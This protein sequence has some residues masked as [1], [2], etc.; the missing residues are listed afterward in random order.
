MSVSKIL[1]NLVKISKKKNNEESGEGYFLEVNVKCLEKLL[2]L[3]NDLPFLHERIKVEK[4]EKFL[5][6]LHDKTEYVIHI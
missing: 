6:N 1:L 4:F 3:H 5:A 2:E